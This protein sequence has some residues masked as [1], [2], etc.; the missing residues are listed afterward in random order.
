M[1]STIVSPV[2]QSP[3]TNRQ[4]RKDFANLQIQEEGR[5]TPL[6]QYEKTQSVPF[7]LTLQEE[8]DSPGKFQLVVDID[9]KRDNSSDASPPNSVAPKKLYAN[10]HGLPSLGYDVSDLYRTQKSSP[11]TSPQKDRQEW[12][13]LDAIPPDFLQKVV[14]DWNVT[15]SRSDST[16][17]TQSRKL[18]DIKARIKKSGKGFVVRLLKGSNGDTNQVAEVEL[19]QQT[20]GELVLPQEL[21]SG[22]PRAELDGTVLPEAQH[23]SENEQSAPFE[24][25]TSN[26]PGIQPPSTV[27]SPPLSQAVLDARFRNSI[28]SEEGFSDAETLIP[29]VRSISD[30][31]E[32]DFT[33]VEPFSR[34]NSVFLARTASVSS[35]VKTPT[36]GLSLVGPVRR[37]EKGTR[38]RVPGKA[39]RSNLHRSDARKSVKFRTHNTFSSIAAGS[40]SLP[41]PEDMYSITR[42]RL[43][44]PQGQPETQDDSAP[45]DYNTW[46]HPIRQKQT[47]KQKLPRRSSAEELARALKPKSRLRLQTDV[48]AKSSS[49]SPVNR[50]RASPR[51][52]KP[53]SS[54]SS[55]IH[56]AETNQ[57]APSPAWS[58][59][60]PSD[61]LRE[62][63][64]E[65]FGTV[66]ESMDRIRERPKTVPRIEEPVSEE[67]TGDISLPP[68]LEIRSIPVNTRNPMVTFCGLALSALAEKAFD[69]LHALR[70]RY[71]SERPV[72]PNH[73]RVRWT[74][75]CGEPLY[76]D[77]IEQRPGAARLLEAYLNR[78]RSHTA[79]SPKSRTSTS[80]S[81]SSIFS[82]AS[83][84]ATP[85]STYNS[86]SSG[87]S[88]SNAPSKHSPP[89]LSA[90]NPF[91]WPMNGYAPESWLLTCANEGR[92][93]PKLVHVDVNAARIRS[94][95]DLALAL[96]AHYEQLNRPWRRWARLRGLTTIEFVQFEVHRNRFAD[97]RA[98]PSMPP[99]TCSSTSTSTSTTSTASD[100]SPS[101]SPHPYT[102]SPVDLIP[103]VGS[104]YLLHLFTH[105]ADYDGELITYLRAPKRRARLECGMGWGI[106]LVEGFLAQRVWGVVLAA[107]GV[108]SVVFAVTWSV[109]EGDVQGAFGV[110]GWVVAVAG[111][112]VGG[113]QG[114]GG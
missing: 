114:W 89:Q 72:A 14:P 104:A 7:T 110:A 81:T 46:Q 3:A 78:P 39:A 106:S 31:L 2:P 38:A 63:L 51:T 49:T 101:P 25:G 45:D 76:D 92:F 40:A 75:T 94:D 20:A 100:A 111:L 17:S 22:L 28:V 93:T 11:P 41:P 70:E 60:H 64:E 47:G 30:R 86:S 12:S 103:P 56:I 44:D 19:G 95:K 13:D 113:V 102:F 91:A 34:D 105:P 62:A 29:D 52:H 21:G 90:A 96:R 36:R 99:A 24:I 85:A 42:R 33:D 23:V 107:F 18:A 108:G 59:V 4:P 68:E 67:N 6:P 98:A 83:T 57:H 66:N 32:E 61:E 80:T 8:K 55:S 79:P 112:V 27:H 1:A 97:I 43:L 15:F 50:R 26:E 71:G 82:S 87:W 84:L 37:V 54:S 73:V 77:F 9:S 65:A 10:L 69:G 109:R 53:S 35:I 16:V 58:E 48:A 5:T 74:C 88:A